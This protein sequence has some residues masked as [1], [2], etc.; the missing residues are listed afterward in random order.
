MLAVSGTDEKLVIFRQ[1]CWT[2]IVEQL[3]KVEKDAPQIGAD[4]GDSYSKGDVEAGVSQ[5]CSAFRRTLLTKLRE[6]P[7]ELVGK[8]EADILETLEQAAEVALQELSA[9]PW[10]S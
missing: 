4:K 2:D 9:K 3:R 7:Q 5:I 1:R 8:T 10:E 6:L